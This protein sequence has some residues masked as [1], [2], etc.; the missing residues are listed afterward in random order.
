M[1]SLTWGRRVLDGIGMLGCMTVLLATGCN[2]AGL[3]EGRRQRVEGEGVVALAGGVRAIA[4]ASGEGITS[5]PLPMMRCGKLCP[6]SLRLT[7]GSG[8][9][10]LSNCRLLLFNVSL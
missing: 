6:G 7:R 9:A 2:L 4:K 3:R 10:G 1:V 8:G 5:A